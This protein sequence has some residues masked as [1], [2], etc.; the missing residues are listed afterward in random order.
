MA[1]LVTCAMQSQGETPWLGFVLIGACV[2]MVIGVLAVAVASFLRYSRCTLCQVQL[3]GWHHYKH[4]KKAVRRRRLYLCSNC[5][6]ALDEAHTTRQRT[7]SSA[8]SPVA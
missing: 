4:A 7:S 5:C 8:D 2:L 1:V 3:W 6:K